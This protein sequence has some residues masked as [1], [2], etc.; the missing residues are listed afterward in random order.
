MNKKDSIDIELKK[1]YALVE[2]IK[3][4]SLGSDYQTRLQFNNI[5]EKALERINEIKNIQEA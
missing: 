4:A 5:K 1:L 3:Q 2:K